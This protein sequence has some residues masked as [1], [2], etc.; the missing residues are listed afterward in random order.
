MMES[1]TRD[2]DK[3]LILDIFKIGSMSKVEFDMAEYVVSFLAKNHIPFRRDKFNNIWNISNVGKP[4]LSAHLDTV[5]DTDDY[6]LAHFAKIHGDILRSYG[7]LG[8][9]DKAG[10]YAIL[11]ILLEYPDTNFV[12]F[13]E[14]EIGGANGSSYWTNQH[15]DEMKENV[16]WS[17]VID[18]R[19]NSDILCNEHFGTYG[20]KEFENALLSVGSKYNLK[21]N[22]GSISDADSLKHYISSSNISAGYYKPHSKQEYVYLPDLKNTIEFLADCIETINDKYEAEEQFQIDEN[23]MFYGNN[24]ESAYKGYDDI[25]FDFDDPYEAYFGGDVYS[26]KTIKQNGRT[27]YFVQSLNDYYSAE[28]LDDIIL[29]I[30]DIQKENGRVL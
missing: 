28:E 1:L 3:E 22:H 17:I 10:I 13:V 6:L 14:E 7:V 19:G 2:I 27:K 4:L 30:I 8:G 16:L 15:G 29:E 11:H 9:D 25:A 21:S 18:R 12:F 24:Y 26:G 20:T 5:Q 23:Y